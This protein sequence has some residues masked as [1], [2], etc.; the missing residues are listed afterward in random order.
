MASADNAID[1]FLQQNIVAIG[2]QDNDEQQIEMLRQLRKELQLSPELRADLDRLIQEIDRYLH[3]PRLEYFGPTVLKEESWDF[4]I[5]PDSPFTPLTWLYHA[6][7]LLWCGMEY[8][9]IWSVP[10]RRRSVFD[11]AVALLEK[12]REHFPQN[13]TIRMYLG[14]PILCTPLAHQVPEAPDWARFQ[15]EGLERLADII[16]WW[17]DNRMQES[18]EFGGGWG[19]D[20]EMWRWWTPILIGF[21]SLKINRAQARFSRAILSQ[22]HMKDGYSAHLTDVEHSSEDSADSI[23]PMMHLEPDN[24]EWR[25][26]ALRLVELM[27]TLWAGRNQRGFLQ[28]KSIDFSVDKI[29]SNP[30]RACDTVYHPRAMQPAL[31]Y[32]QRTNDLHCRALFTAWMDTWADATRRAERGKP[33]GIIPSAIHWPD[34][35]VGGLDGPWWDPESNRDTSLYRWPSAMAQMI[36]TL[37]QTYAMTNDAKYLE[38]VRSMADIRRKYLI[39]KSEESPEPGRESWCAEKIALGDVLAKYRFLTNNSEFDDLLADASGPYLQFRL[40]ED[41]GCLVKGLEKNAKALG[42]NFAGYTSEV[43]YT[44]RVLRFP[45]LFS[46]GFLSPKQVPDIFT[47]NPEL[48]YSTVTGDPGGPLYFPLNR[49]RW[50]TPPREIAALVTKTEPDCLEAQ[51]LH[52]GEKP[53]EMGAELY[54]FVPGR[55]VY[56]LEGDPTENTGQIQITGARTTLSFTLPPRS[57]T[58]FKVK[59]DNSR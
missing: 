35:Q 2:N 56:S 15:R 14:E 51:L 28:F 30:E 55:Y 20:C 26:K 40:H 33:A 22:A 57:L 21:Q 38:P 45:S 59:Q 24:P 4:G 43:R 8:G 11:K 23:T 54:M 42:T 5:R 19:D 46:A 37:L 29:R 47:P 48:L 1:P 31:L 17:I 32:W 41:T 18:G 39:Q 6:R 3:S 36:N 58:V 49:V 25:D 50:L 10:H 44:D 16:E 7:M 53:R 52:F 12:A 34:G 27:E 9:D 13:R